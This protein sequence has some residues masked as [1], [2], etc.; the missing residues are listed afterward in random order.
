M[1]HTT[2]DHRRACITPSIP[3]SRLCGLIQK[4]SYDPAAANRC[5]GTWWARQG[6]HLDQG[7]NTK[8]SA[9]FASAKIYIRRL[10]GE[11]MRR[12]VNAG[13]R[14]KP[15]TRNGYGFCTL[16]TGRR[17]LHIVEADD[18]KKNVVEQ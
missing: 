2:D 7:T 10:V 17:V 16:V 11:G 3:P 1:R 6:K 8:L 9:S 4:I 18:D 13:R 5:I 14:V 12:R 15:G